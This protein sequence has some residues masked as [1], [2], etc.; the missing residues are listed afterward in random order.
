MNIVQHK[1]FLKLQQMFAEVLRG[2]FTEDELR[3]LVN[4]G[5]DV[6]SILTSGQYAYVSR[7]EGQKTTLS[8]MSRWPMDDVDDLLIVAGR[9]MAGFF[10]PRSS[11][12]ESGEDGLITSIFGGV[13][14][15]LAEKVGDALKTVDIAQTDRSLQHVITGAVDDD[16]QE[17]NID[18]YDPTR[19]FANPASLSSFLKY[20]TN[21]E[22][23]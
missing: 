19:T 5:I 23:R 20:H 17:D 11:F 12:G 18:D 8:L 4:A 14:K 13:T 10:T 7:G 6:N 9:D 3:T 1:T 21:R 2:C 16:A 15:T 22:D